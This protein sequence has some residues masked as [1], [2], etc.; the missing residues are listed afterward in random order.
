MTETGESASDSSLK[1]DR[2]R[3]DRSAPEP[4]GRLRRPLMWLILIAIVGGGAFVYFFVD[5]GGSEEAIEVRVE[6]VRMTS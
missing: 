5:F 2:L 1:L 4:S 3:I 6:T